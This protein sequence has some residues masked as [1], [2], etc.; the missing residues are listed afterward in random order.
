[1]ARTL[2]AEASKV[3]DFTGFLQAL[4]GV[5][6]S[7]FFISAAQCNLYKMLVD[8]FSPKPKDIQFNIK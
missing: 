6:L 7:V 8:T 2:K 3:R 4:T 1:M 5:L